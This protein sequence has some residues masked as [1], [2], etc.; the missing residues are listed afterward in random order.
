[1]IW[2]VHHDEGF[3]IGRLRWVDIDDR[4][5][6]I[7]RFRGIDFGQRLDLDNIFVL[8]DR[9]ERPEATVCAIMHRCFVP[10]TFEQ[11]V[12]AAIDKTLWEAGVNLV[13][14]FD[15]VGHRHRLTPLY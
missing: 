1:M 10:K 11:G 13:E 5:T 4:N 7:F 12:G 3:K 15:K 8:A 6:P 9:P 2:R 14:R